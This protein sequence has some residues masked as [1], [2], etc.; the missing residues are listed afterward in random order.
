MIR[1]RTYRV[2]ERATHFIAMTETHNE[3]QQGM[4]ILCCRDAHTHDCAT[5]RCG[6]QT[7]C[8]WQ[9]HN[10]L[11]CVLAS[12]FDAWML[13]CV[14]WADAAVCSGLPREATRTLSSH[15]RNGEL[16]KM[17]PRL[18]SLQFSLAALPVS[19]HFSRGASHRP[20]LMRMDIQLSWSRHEKDNQQ[21]CRSLC[22]ADCVS[23]IVY[24]IASIVLVTY[25]IS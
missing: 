23:L 21:S 9:P 6:N 25:D 12:S 8:V 3:M 4:H 24:W 19:K 15:S 7:T 11:S 18:C 2:A 17:T 20:S 10:L 13:M 1:S 22:F 14:Q 16:E 5:A